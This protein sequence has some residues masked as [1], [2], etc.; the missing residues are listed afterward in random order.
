L[1][2]L[3]AQ[4]LSTDAG[5]DDTPIRGGIDLENWMKHAQ[6]LLEVSTVEHVSNP[7]RRF[8]LAPEDTDERQVQQFFLEQWDSEEDAYLVGLREQPQKAPLDK[9][10]FKF[11]LFLRRRAREDFESK[12]YA[13]AKLSL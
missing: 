13:T 9:A 8:S 6:Q 5:P 10:E 4:N 7:G 11:I 12:D 1:L 3:S 2:P